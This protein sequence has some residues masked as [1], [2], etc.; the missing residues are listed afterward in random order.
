MLPRSIGTPCQRIHELL[1]AL[2]LPGEGTQ[3]I[4]SCGKRPARMTRLRLM[5]SGGCDPAPDQV[6][7][8]WQRDTEMQCK[9]FLSSAPVMQAGRVDLLAFLHVPHEH[10]RRIWSTN[11]LEGRADSKCVASLLAAAETMG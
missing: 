2:G 9:Q 10:W 1:K 6:R 5:C 11:P 7:G 3:P 4:A 8:P